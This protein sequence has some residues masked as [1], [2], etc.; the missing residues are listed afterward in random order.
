MLEISINKRQSSLN[1]TTDL[2]RLLTAEDAEHYREIW[3][4]RDASKMCALVAGD[5][6]WLMMIRFDGDPGFSSRNRDYAGSDDATLA[7]KLANGQ[8][9]EY[10]AAWTVPKAIWLVALQHFA[11]R[12]NFIQTLNGMLMDKGCHPH[13]LA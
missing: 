9:D 2:E 12:D 5:V 3:I 11:E 4:G 13:Q 7:F 6:A 10:P 1:N 8:I